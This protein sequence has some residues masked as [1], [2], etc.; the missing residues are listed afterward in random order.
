MEAAQARYFTEHH[1]RAPVFPATL[2]GE[3]CDLQTAFFATR[4]RHSAEVE[5]VERAVA[6]DY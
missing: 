3:V 2:P 1:N 6:R 5:R 4:R